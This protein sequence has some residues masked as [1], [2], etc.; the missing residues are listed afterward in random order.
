MKIIGINHDM[1]ISSAALIIDGKIVSA[2]AEERL[3]REKMTRSFPHNAIRYCLKKANLSLNQIDYIANSYNPSVHFKKFHPIFSNYRRFRGDY[4][5][6]I[7]DHLINKI[8]TDNSESEYTKQEIQLSKNKLKVFYINHHLSHAANGFYLSPFKKSAVLTA[9]GA[10]EDDTVN[11]LLGENNNLTL[12]NRIKIPHS[13]GSFYSTFT[14][15]LGYKPENDEWKVM[16]LSSYGSKKNKFYKLIKKMVSFNNDGTFNLDQ[17]YFKQ[18]IFILP[19]LY[20][21]KFLKALGPARKKGEKFTQRHY[22]I[23][24]AMQEIFEEIMFHMLKN[25]YTRTKSQNVVLSGGSFMNSVLNGKVRDNTPFKNVWI[26]SCPDDSGQSIGSALYLYNNILK[27]KKRYELKHNFFGPSYKNDEIKS[28]LNK[29]KI[30]YTYDKNISKI[31][32]NHIAKGK[33]IG[34]FQ[35]A[36]EFGQR[37]LGNRSIV[38]DPRYNISKEK[39]NSAVKYRES[40]RPFAPS[41]LKEEC[42]NY[43]EMKKNDEIQFMEK[44]VR[45]RKDKKHL[46]KAVVHKDLSARVQ[47]VDK[48]SNP[49]FYELIKEFKNLTGIPCLLNTSFNVNGEP[50][51]CSPEDAIKTFYSCGLDILV[52]GNYIVQK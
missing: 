4:F 13:T 7:P 26:S 33:L 46:I 52:M 41:V 35:G 34:W 30:N 31:I 6:S 28:V 44:V 38:A 17:N 36:M 50:I 39:V 5:Y 51:V 21:E 49:K 47:T 14:E 2:I 10:G 27:N 37:S 40:Y 19:N 1:Y 42:S 22:E 12:L 23:A 43:F 8:S 16:A 32:S 20:T 3:T 11:F 48:V 9:D 15:Y 29:F 45:V 18:N 24:S 25:L